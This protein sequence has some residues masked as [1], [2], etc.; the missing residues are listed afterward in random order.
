MNN[1]SSKSSAGHTQKQ[2]KPQDTLPEELLEKMVGALEG[3]L[4]SVTERLLSSRVVVWPLSAAVNVGLRGARAVQRRMPGHK[5]THTQ[6]HK[7]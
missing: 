5:A 4:N 7:Q 6:E 1:E 2:R 3:P